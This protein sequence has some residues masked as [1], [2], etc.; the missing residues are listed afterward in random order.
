[1]SPVTG[2][3]I[4]LSD[5]GGTTWTK[6]WEAATVTV[7]NYT[8]DANGITTGDAS[9]TVCANT[10][11]SYRVRIGV[12]NRIATAWSEASAASST[13]GT[14]TPTAGARHTACD[15]NTLTTIFL[16]RTLVA[17]GPNGARPCGWWIN[18]TGQGCMPTI[19][20][21]QGTGH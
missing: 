20:A 4:D 9:A 11:K 15:F 18:T 13:V 12:T 3:Q 16:T 5:D 1:M 8:T 17:S 7:T 10:G 6:V 14:H 19:M 21:D 2:F